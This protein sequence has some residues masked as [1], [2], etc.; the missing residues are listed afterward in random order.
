LTG[1][2]ILA[3]AA[4]LYAGGFYLQA[5]KPDTEEARKANAVLTMKA[6]GCNDPA[7][8]TV[9]ATAEGLVNGERRTIALKLT[10]LSE[11]GSYALTRQ[12]PKEGRWVIHLSATSNIGVAEALAVEGPGGMEVTHGSDVE[13]MLRR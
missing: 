11:P 2:A 8:T 10:P 6:T 3:L 7:K 13:A 4:Q 1:G 9:T 5:G 12:W